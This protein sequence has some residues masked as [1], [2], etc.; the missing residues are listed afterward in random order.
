MYFVKQQNDETGGQQN[1]IIDKETLRGKKLLIAEDDDVIMEWMVDAFEK[2]GVWVDKTYDGNEVVALFEESKPFEYDAILMDMGMPEC[3]GME[4][5]FRIRHLERE[6]AKEIPI[7]AYTGFPLENE[8]EFLRRNRIQIRKMCF[9]KKTLKNTSDRQEVLLYKSESTLQNM[10][11]YVA[12]YFASS[13]IHC[14]C[15]VFKLR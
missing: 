8:E 2:Y 10:I 5:T 11:L 1:K 13:F 14:Y 9:M 12:A 6:D 15:S 3:N 4:A 7:I